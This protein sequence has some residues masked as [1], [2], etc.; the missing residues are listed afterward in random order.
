VPVNPAL[1]FLLAPA[2]PGTLAPAHRA[3]LDR[4]GLTEETIRIHG[5]RSVPPGLIA[6]LLGWDS[7][8]ITSA[9]LL[10]YPNPVRALTGRGPQWLDH[11]VVRLVPPFRPQGGGQ[12]K[13]AQPR[14]TS[15]RVYFPRL[16]LPEVLA[17]ADEPLSVLEGQKKAC[18]FSQAGYPAIAISG[19]EGWH[20]RGSKAL[21]EDFALMPLRGR[22]VH[23]IPDADVKTNV[24]VQRGALGFCHALERAGARPEVLLLPAEFPQAEPA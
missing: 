17:S 7:P 18:A 10:P 2:Y 14:G 20:M 9:Y 19:V 21:L 16:G 8:R 23:V 13:Y 4:S 15:P 12:I 1:T 3:D 24:N 5:F 6:Q 11:I 22:V